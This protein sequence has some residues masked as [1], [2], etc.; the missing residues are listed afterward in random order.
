VPG[1]QEL[2][3]RGACNGYV[4]PAVWRKLHPI[5]VWTLHA[6][7][8]TPFI[9]D[10]AFAHDGLARHVV[11]TNLR[12]WN[13]TTKSALVKLART[14]EV[15]LDVGAY[16]GL[17][18]LLA[19][20]A[21]PALRAVMVE[22]NLD[23]LVQLRSNVA[24]NGLEDRV[25]IVTKALS[26][27]AGESTLVIPADDS[28]ASLVQPRDGDRIVK[29]AVTTGDEVIGDLPVGLI[30]IDV[31]GFEPDVLAGLSRVLTTRHPPVIA[32]CLNR[33]ALER[34]R[35]TA[36]AFGYTYAYHLDRDRLVPVGPGF[37]HPKRHHDFL[38][39]AEP[40]STG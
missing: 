38:L 15:F 34:L 10:S 12:H 18:T 31:E 4:P 20:A 11:W 35:D 23:K 6:P 13:E 24:L 5:G 33:T 40:V 26:R 7:D 29:V 28:C 3:R 9:Y 25:T 30:K 1:L 2:I 17:Y 16:S 14:A 19:C 32:E 22:P 36:G 27:A 8:G 37:V 39:T 21:N